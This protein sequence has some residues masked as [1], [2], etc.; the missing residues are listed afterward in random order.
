MKYIDIIRYYEE[1][2]LLIVI[3]LSWNAKEQADNLYN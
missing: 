3:Y 2:K 1:Y